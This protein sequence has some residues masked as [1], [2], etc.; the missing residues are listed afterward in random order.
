MRLDLGSDWT[1]DEVEQYR[2]DLR[3]LEW[4]RDKLKDEL[5]VEPGRIAERY[6]LRDL[7][8]FPLGLRFVLPA[9]VIE[10]GTL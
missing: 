1:V 6:R 5:E 8:A 9:S 10:R 4:R 7:R 3:M 2:N